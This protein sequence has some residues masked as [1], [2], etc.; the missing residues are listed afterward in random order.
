M[1]HSTIFLKIILSLFFFG[2]VSYSHSQIKAANGGWIS[3]RE[4]DRFVKKEMDSLGLPGMSLA[5]FSDGKI[6]Y[7]RAL[8]Y[9]NKET[10]QKVDKHSLFE[11]ASVSKPVFSYLAM[12]MV[13]NGKLDLDRPLYQYLPY[14][15]IEYDDRYK[16]I[17]ARMV[18]AHM[19]GLPNWRWDRGDSSYRGKRDGLY[20]KYTPGSRFSYSGEGFLYLSMVVA[21][22]NNG[23]LKNLDSLF[24]QQVAVPLGMKHSYFSWNK[25]VAKHKVMG[26]IGGKND[27]RGWPTPLRTLDSTKFIA[28]GG[29]HTEAVDYAR[30]LIGLMENKDLKK[31]Y[32]DQM[33]TR[34]IEVPKDDVEY[35]YL[36]DTAWGLGIALKSRKYGPCYEHDGDNGSF[37]SGFMFSLRQKNGFVYFTNGGDK[38]DMFNTDLQNV[39]LEGK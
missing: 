33:L 25:Y 23:D 26:Y 36:K 29:L 32:V 4:M 10:G 21:H 31:Q 24:Q 27:T 6:V 34:Q 38:G 37:K 13:E 3:Y 35:I 5:I 16:A 15:D 11:A 7:H 9:A 8:G 1:K 17:T 28:A 14:P 19:S 39:L 22:L 30:F 2:N 20:I 18:L 12:K